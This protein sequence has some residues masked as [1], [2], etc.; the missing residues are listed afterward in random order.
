MSS[1][2]LS[3]EPELLGCDQK[4]ALGAVK[5]SPELKWLQEEFRFRKR[6]KMA[7][8][9][10]GVFGPVGDYKLLYKRNFNKGYGTVFHT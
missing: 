3:W 4:G 1:E 8:T 9:E 2:S 7:K 5:T 6:P 10:V